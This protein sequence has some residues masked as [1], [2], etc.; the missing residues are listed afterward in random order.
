ML[1]TGLWVAAYQNL[2]KPNKNAFISET[3]HC[4]YSS[5]Y[6]LITIKTLGAKLWK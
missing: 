6:F 5:I 3:K 4:L 1:Y 2:I